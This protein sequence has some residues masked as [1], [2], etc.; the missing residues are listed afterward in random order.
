MKNIFINKEQY[1]LIKESLENNRELPSWLINAVHNKQFPLSSDKSFIDEAIMR[2][3][4][5]AYEN[6]V[7]SFSD[8]ITNFPVDKIE[9]KLNKLILICQKKENKIKAEL[10]KLCADIVLSLFELNGK[11]LELECNLVTSIPQSKDFHVKPDTKVPVEY[12]SIDEINDEDSDEVRRRYTNA[13]TIGAALELT[14]NLLTKCVKE[15]FELDEELPYLYTK[16]IKINNYLLLI[17]HDEITDDNNQ[18]DAYVETSVDDSSNYIKILA[19]GII[20]PFLL[21]EA[22]RGCIEALT[23]NTLPEKRADYIVNRCDTLQ[24]EPY[25]MI[26]GRVFWNSICGEEFDDTYTEK[27]LQKLMSLDNEKFN[28]LMDEVLVGTK[29]GRDGMDKIMSKIKYDSDYQ[30]FEKDLADKRKEKEIIVDGYFTESEL[31]GE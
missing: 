10:E 11:E 5:A 12:D 28:T 15:I 3:L 8:D 4:E 30:S 24:D 21:T 9:N 6:A 23:F 18:Q 7:S 31:G 14:D 16:I 13:I 22:I 27:L 26:L 17:K 29:L 1:R 20:F 19:E 2:M 25:Y